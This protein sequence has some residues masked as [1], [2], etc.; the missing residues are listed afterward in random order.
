MTESLDFALAR[1]K[2]LAWKAN[3]KSFL[4]N[5]AAISKEEMVSAQK[6]QL[7][8]WI[9]A[10]GLEKY[11]DIPEMRQLEKVHLELHAI[12]EL[13]VNLKAVGR[14]E[15]AERELAKLEPCSQDLLALL[16]TV[17]KKVK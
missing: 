15:A 2:H 9:Y 6:C 4:K 10:E 5:E 13:V 14:D 1:L 16:D 17:E 7:G 12:V 8:K 11:G 3:L